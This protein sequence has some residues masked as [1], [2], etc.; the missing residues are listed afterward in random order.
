M[1]TN[2]LFTILL[3]RKQIA[4]CLSG[5]VAADTLRV[6][7]LRKFNEY[8]EQMGKFGFLPDDLEQAVVSLEWNEEK[9]VAKY[10]LRE[11]KIKMIQYQLVQDELVGPSI[12]GC[13]IP[14]Q[15]GR[16]I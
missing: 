7:I 3:D 10:Y 11:R 6:K 15:A 1:N 8:K 13:A 2:E 9:Q 5:K 12:N 4:L 16:R 14:S